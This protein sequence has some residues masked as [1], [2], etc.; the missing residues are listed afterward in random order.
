MLA[1]IFG[2][3]VFQTLFPPCS[4]DFA[5]I[6]CIFL[7]IISFPATLSLP[8]GSDGPIIDWIIVLRQLVFLI[9]IFFFSVMGG[10]LFSYFHWKKL[11]K[12]NLQ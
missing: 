3:K 2:K 4:M 7:V 11:K 10:T 6:I 5:K 8:K 9:Y 1:G 12:R